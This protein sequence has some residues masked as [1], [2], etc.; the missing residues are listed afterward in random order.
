MTLRFH[1]NQDFGEIHGADLKSWGFSGGL[2]RKVSDP[3]RM[4]PDLTDH[5]PKSLPLEGKVP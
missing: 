3:P 4:S 1:R 5:L 2:R